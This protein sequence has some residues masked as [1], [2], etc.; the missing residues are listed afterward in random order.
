MDGLRSE[1]LGISSRPLEFHTDI[2]TILPRPSVAAVCSVS[3]CR[4]EITD[5]TFSNRILL[6][7]TVDKFRAKVGG[8]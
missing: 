8:F 2:W 4:L 3:S 5:V 6:A 7:S 1:G